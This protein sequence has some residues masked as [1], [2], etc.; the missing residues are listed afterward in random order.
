M[1]PLFCSHLDLQSAL[2]RTF[3]FYPEL[4]L[5]SDAISKCLNQPLIEV[6]TSEI[7]ALQLVQ[8][9]QLLEHLAHAF[10]IDDV[11]VLEG[12]MNEVWPLFQVLEDLL[13]LLLSDPLIFNHK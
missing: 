12:Q 6:V 13:R 4:F 3:V 7:D 2:V 5:H 9:L 1:H 8:V 11:V 10:Y